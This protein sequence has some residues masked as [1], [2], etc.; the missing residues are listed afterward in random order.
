MRNN[1]QKKAKRSGT[2]ALPKTGYQLGG[3]MGQEE[4]MKAT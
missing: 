4:R 2:G 1:M 3:T